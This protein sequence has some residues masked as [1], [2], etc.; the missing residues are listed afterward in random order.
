MSMTAETKQILGYTVGPEYSQKAAGSK[1]KPVY[2]LPEMKRPCTHP[3]FKDHD[4]YPYWHRYCVMCGAL[5]DV[6]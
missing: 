5:I 6:I 1:P 4:I 3:V 2:S